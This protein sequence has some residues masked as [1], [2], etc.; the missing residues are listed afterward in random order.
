M[1]QRFPVKVGLIGYGAIG[2]VVAS[3]ILHETHG[4][5]SDRVVLT[6]ILVKKP[7]DLPVNSNES[8]A[9]LLTNDIDEFFSKGPFDVVVEAAGQQIVRDLFQKILLAGTDVLCTS[10]GALTDDVLF[11][12]LQ[13]A[14]LKGNSQLLLA[15]GAM[16]S[17]DWMHS[18]SGDCDSPSNVTATQCKPPESWRGA[19]F[20]PGTTNPLPDVIDFNLVSEPTTFFEGTAREAAKFYPKNSNILAMLALA[21]AGLD[22]TV[23]RLVADPIGISLNVKYEGSAGTLSVDVVGKKSKSNPRT[24]QVVPLAVIKSL[25]NLANPVAYGV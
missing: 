9:S 13:Q 2:S 24:S 18:S 25:R 19:R 15:S 5:T 17:L 20:E 3:A 4:I 21:T 1:S 16:P 8:S 11:K 6:A 7:R 23:V 12:N 10:M 22:N 14:A